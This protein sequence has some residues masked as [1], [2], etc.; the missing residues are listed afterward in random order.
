[1]S[2]FIFMLTQHDVTVKD[3][4]EIARS[5]EPLEIDVVGFKDIGLDLRAQAELVAVL[6]D[7]G[8]QVALEVVSEHRDDELRAIEAGLDLRVD[9][10]LGGVNVADGLAQIA[11]AGAADVRYCPFPGRIVGHPSVLEGTIDSVVNSAV[12]LAATNGVWGLDLLAYRFTGD[13]D[14]LMRRVVAAVDAPVIIAG[15]VADA[16]RISVIKDA[17]AWGFTV[18][19]AIFERRFVA[20]GAIHEQLAAVIAAASASDDSSL[21]ARRLTHP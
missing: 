5:I 14:T 20:G 2:R 8:R 6:R 12:K 19:S 17:G 4:V 7:Q 21:P 15:S 18:G 10:L 9:L 1:M 16:D 11:G 13:A 3:A